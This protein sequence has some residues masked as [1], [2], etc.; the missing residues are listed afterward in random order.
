MVSSLPVELYHS[1]GSSIVEELAY[2]V[3]YSDELDGSTIEI[4]MPTTKFDSEGW[5]DDVY[6]AIVSEIGRINT[7]SYVTK[8]NP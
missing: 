1:D 4:E 3:I 6:H 7:L 2:K 5:K 8:L